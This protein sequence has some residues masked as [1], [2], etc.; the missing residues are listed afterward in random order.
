MTYILSLG[1]ADQ[2]I[3]VADRRVTGHPALVSDE[4][5]KAAI[6]RTDRERFAFAFTGLAATTDG[7]RTETALLEILAQSG[8]PEYAIGPML[9]RLMRRATE[10]FRDDPRINSLPARQRRLSV[11]FIGY[12][13]HYSPPRLGIAI[14]TNFQDFEAGRDSVEPWAEFR[15]CTFLPADATDDNPTWVQHI[16]AWQA[17]DPADTAALRQMLSERRPARAIV[18]KAVSVVRELADRPAAQGTVG[19]QL[20]SIILPRDPRS[21]PRMQYHTATVSGGLFLP[22]EVIV[23]RRA[24]L[25]IHDRSIR[26]AGPAGPSAIMNVP[27][28]HRNAPCPCGSGKR[29]RD[30]HRARRR[31]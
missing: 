27:E 21:Q 19:R 31:R 1:N 10:V 15:L 8:P 29:Y 26:P 14:L 25:L 7:Y 24:T 5:N 2:A 28:V 20:S 12:L 6:L 30:C 18:E 9:P 16:G 11:K 23:T 17:T 22:N 13:N 4:A 3:L